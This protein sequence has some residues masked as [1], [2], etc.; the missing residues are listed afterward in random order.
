MT[1]FERVK[2]GLEIYNTELKNEKP[3]LYLLG[4]LDCLK[5]MFVYYGAGQTSEINKLYEEID[6]LIF[7]LENE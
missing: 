1:V 4:Y 2:N 3:T 5:S 7:N 6:S